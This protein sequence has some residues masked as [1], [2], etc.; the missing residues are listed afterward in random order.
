MS[1]NNRRTSCGIVAAIATLLALPAC[2]TATLRASELIADGRLRAISVNDAELH[3]LA[4]GSGPAIVF[5]HG[6]LANYREWLPV[7]ELLNGRYTTIVY[8][9][10]HSDPNR[11]NPVSP[12]HSPK[13]EADDL[14]G[15]ISVLN[16][17]PVHVVGVSYGAS[18]SLLLALRRPEL[19]RSLSLVEPPLISWLPSIEGGQT[20]L[21][22]FNERLV[23]P[24]RAAF[25]AGDR[26][27]A[28]AI[29][30][31]YFAGPDA[32]EQIPPNV[33]VALRAN[34][35]DWEV[36]FRSSELLPDISRESLRSLKVPVLM[37]SGASSYDLGKLVD[38]ELERTLPNVR[39][40]L[41]PDGTHEACSE[42]PTVCATA[43]GAFVDGL[44]R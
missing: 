24:V 34:L 9:R 27:A 16:G 12:S 39:R 29:T 3:Y 14:A 23:D 31:R 28:F 30:L 18:T 36:M 43:I 10:R 17:G 11:G 38:G 19:V 35:R 4:T 25:L 42:Q 20:V 32:M 22:D 6:G 8:S 1:H 15:L 41:V 7:T 5:V 33:L 40:V 2:S 13:T 21:D 44:E 37:L 26:D